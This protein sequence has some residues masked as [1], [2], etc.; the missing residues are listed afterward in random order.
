MRIEGG[1]ALADLG[2]PGVS[3]VKRAARGVASGVKSTG[4]G[5][6]KASH[7]ISP[8]WEGTGGGGW[9]TRIGKRL[10]MT[11]I[12]VAGVMCNLKRYKNSKACRAIGSVSWAIGKRAI[13]KAYGLPDGSLDQAETALNGPQAKKL[14]PDVRELLQ[15]RT[16]EPSI[17]EQILDTLGL[18]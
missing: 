2:I 13:E 16:E 1:D 8:P 12:P 5:I 4:R 6:A 9:A 15:R 11:G 14:P 7:A 17:W 10:A 18:R 3:L